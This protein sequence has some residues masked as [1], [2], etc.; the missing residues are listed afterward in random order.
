MALVS[1]PHPPALPHGDIREV[2]PGIYFVT[3]T[4][5]MPGPL[6]VRFSRNMTIVRE[7]ERL[8]LVNSVR[9]DDAGLAAL[10]ALGKVTDVI[11]LAANH[12]MDDPFYRDRYRAKVWAVAGQRYTSGFDTN[13]PDVYLEPDVAID[14]RTELPL[15]GA[16]L[17]L[18][19]SKPPEGLLVL[20]RHGGT[21][22]SGDCLQHW[23]EPD[24]YFSFLGKT[25]MRMMGF[26]R[27]HNVGPGW[28]KQCKPPKDE[29][30]KILELDF[31]NVLPSHGGAVIGTARDQYRPAIDRVSAP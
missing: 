14:E 6:P 31:T 19:H 1:R 11:R 5:G 7:G 4:V 17:Y 26:I 28:L 22:V 13:A 18:I 20:E 15:A 23:A 29:L 3:G 21:I 16:R 27:P 10:D 12:G 30:R 9:L 24:A 8:V 2:L 25:M